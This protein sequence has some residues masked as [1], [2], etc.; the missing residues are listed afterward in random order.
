MIK[1]A[2]NSFKDNIKER[3]SNPFLGTFLLVWVIHN[4]QLVYSFFYFDSDWKLQKRIE[5]FKQYWTE[6]T[7]LWN[8]LIVALLTVCVIVITYMFL[9]LSRLITN[10]FENV[11]IPFV[12]TLTKGKIVTRE[13]HQNALNRIE[14]LE[15]K[16]EAERK[17]KNEAILERDE[18]ERKTA[19]PTKTTVN[20]EVSDS[21]SGEYTGLI[22]LA[23]DTL[24][25]EDFDQKLI[26]I[27][28]GF[29]FNRGPEP[30][31]DFLLKLGLI[32]VVE[33]NSTSGNIKYTFTE[34]GLRFKKEYYTSRSI[35]K[36]SSS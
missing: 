15:Q 27:S 30:N 34:D 18:L 35:E 32:Y 28:K 3:I 20:L 17:L 2:F 29:F 4:W 11:V 26:N 14:T 5:Y 16:V 6:H 1:D 7:F 36:G 22:K 25:S 31:I 10:Y 33:R 12:H 23:T 21:P 13:I 9:A 8:L 19:E 24:N